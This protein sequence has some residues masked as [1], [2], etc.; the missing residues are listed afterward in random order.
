MY[1]NHKPAR[2]FCSLARTLPSPMHHFPIA[3]ASVG[4]GKGA[5]RNR[6]VI[7]V[8]QTTTAS[9][10]IWSP[11]ES[12][13]RI[14]SA[15][16]D[17]HAPPT[18]IAIFNLKDIPVSMDIAWSKLLGPDQRGVKAW[19]VWRTRH[20]PRSDHLHVEL[21]AHGCALFRIER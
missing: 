15:S 19:D 6:D 12:S 16:T 13:L 20:I 14:W 8:N 10:E 1:V 9:S 2:F 5:V 3:A 4:D 18:Y 11:D 17:V 21:S 7:A